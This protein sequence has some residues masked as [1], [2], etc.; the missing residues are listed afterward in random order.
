[1]DWAKF[2]SGNLFSGSALPYHVGMQR[3]DHLIVAAASLAEGGAW[4]SAQLGVD[5]APGGKHVAMGTHNL[6]MQL[7]DSIYLEV[8]AIDP[9][10]A[11][12]ARPRWFGLDSALMRDSLRH[13]PRLVTWALNTPDLARLAQACNFDLGTPT[14]L[15]RDRL[16][17][18]IALTDDGRLLADG[19]LPY[20]IQWHSAPHPA[21]AMADPGC[22]LRRLTLYHNRPDWLASCIDELDAGSLVRITPLDDDHAPYLEATIETPTRATVTLES[23]PITR[24]G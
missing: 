6:L 1:M 23:R 10:A 3:I 7:G 9:A 20:C 2:Y 17:W 24:R 12:P 8:I 22:R 15:A 14:R 13:G 5:I 21:L 18:Q 19:L 4:V 11:A 16:E